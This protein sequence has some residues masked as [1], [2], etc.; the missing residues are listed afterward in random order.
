[1]ILEYEGYYL[2]IFSSISS[3][4]SIL[5]NVWGSFVLVSELTMPICLFNMIGFG[6]IDTGKIWGSYFNPTSND[7]FG[8]LILLDIRPIGQQ[9][10]GFSSSESPTQY[11]WGGR[12]W[13]HPV[14]QYSADTVAIG[15]QSIL[16]KNAYCF[17]SMAPWTVGMNRPTLVG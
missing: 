11:G 15:W 10:L 8:Q 12:V 16:W 1:M 13:A 17:G 2:Q 6:D 3:I 5:C 7:S 14:V 9:W 4:Y